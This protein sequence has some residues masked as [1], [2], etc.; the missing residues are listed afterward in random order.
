MSREVKFKY[1]LKNWKLGIHLLFRTKHFGVNNLKWSTFPSIWG[2]SWHKI[3]LGIITI[4][5]IINNWKGIRFRM[6]IGFIPKD[7]YN[8]LFK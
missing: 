1:C 3:L 6:E 7:E 4:K 8:I 5:P 2:W